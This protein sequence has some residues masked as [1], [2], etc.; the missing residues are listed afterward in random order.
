MPHARAFAPGF[1]NRRTW[2]RR[3]A[4]L[5]AWPAGLA[6]RRAHAA[7]LPITIDAMRSAQETEIGVYYRYTEFSRKAREEGYQGIAYLFV[8]FG[9]AEFIHAGN[10]G[11]ILSRLDV[12][13]PPIPK[14]PFKVGDTRENLIVAANGEAH[15][16][17]NFYP[18]LLERITPEGHQDAMAAVRYAWETEKR[19]R[20]KIRQIQRWS[21]TFFDQ[22]ARHID[23]KTGTYYVCQVCGN[24]VNAVPKSQCPICSSA[25]TH[26]RRIEPPA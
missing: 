12:E 15:S 3:T 7:S 19:H 26:F 18:K 21:P 1:V 13:V 5:V 10:F 9:A 16:V 11:R 14:P 22:V 24:T 2:L 23:S 20:D 17:D 6:G 25:S 8:A 4:A